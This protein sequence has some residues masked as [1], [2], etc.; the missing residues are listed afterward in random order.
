MEILLVESLEKLYLG[1]NKG[2]KLTSLPEDIIKL[3]VGT[4][5]GGGSLLWLGSS[6]APKCR[7]EGSPYVFR[8]LVQQQARAIRI[9]RTPIVSV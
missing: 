6:A 3:Q 8:N 1:Q 5:G 2:I 9:G 4:I 7:T